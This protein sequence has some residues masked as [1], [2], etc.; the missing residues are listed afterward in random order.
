M[1]RKHLLILLLMGL[2]LPFLNTNHP[3]L[4]QD[5][6]ITIGMIDVP[7]RLDPAIADDFTTWEVLSHLYTGLTRHVSG[8]NDYELALA[9]DYQISEDGMTHTFTLPDNATFADGTPIT[10]ETFANSIN[11]VITL[12]RS[13]A[14]IMRNVVEQV[15]ATNPTTLEFTLFEP[16]PY[17]KAL[18]SLPPFFAVHPND[19]PA[20]DIN[21]EP[22]QLIG[23]GPYTLTSWAVGSYINLSAN[24]DYQF[25]EPARTE[26]IHIQGY[27]TSEDLRLALVNGNVDV[28]WR[29]VILA[30][31]VTT[32]AQDEN[33][34][35]IS[36]PSARMWYFYINSDTRFEESSDPPVR[37]AIMTVL[38]RQR[39]V[40]SYFSG[41]TTPA[42]SLVPSSLEAYTPLWDSVPDSEQAEQI[43]EDAGYRI[44]QRN[45]IIVQIQSSQTAY[46]D[47]YTRAITGM[48][49]DFI[50]LRMNI[51]IQTNNDA[52]TFMDAL[53]EGRYQAAVFAWTPVVL[54]PDAYLRPLLHSE[55]R[56]ANWGGYAQPEIDTALDEARAAPDL[57]SQTE[58]YQEA[59]ALIQD[60]YQLAPLWQDT[61]SV[62]YRSDI[63]GVTIEPTYFLHYDLLERQ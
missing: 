58:F 44:N 32:A 26:N 18:V 19:F 5:N 28:A 11:R 49:R 56:I 27:A 59:Q 24:P 6:T 51:T 62:L 53:Q 61:V 15:T 39:V 21:R 25:G 31:A 36:I 33:I 8:T 17:F 20:D 7:V 40:D 34:S 29:D 41:L 22:T 30:D 54:H 35:L 9:T 43:L 10:A 13:G 45:N 63:Q 4:A 57:A 12:D 55:S 38:D 46:G 60:E 1:L 47:A 23:N 3:S 42:Y 52:V 14:G 48:R 37:H 16:V 50:F 2:G